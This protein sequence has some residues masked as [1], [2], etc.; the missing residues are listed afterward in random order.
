MVVRFLDRAAILEDKETSAEKQSPWRLATVT[1][2]EEMKLILNMI[3]IWIATLPF[4]VTVSQT[5]TF[6]TKPALSCL[7]CNVINNCYQQ[8]AKEICCSNHTKVEGNA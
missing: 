4:G 2:V 3:P 7:L 1:K 6:F 5:S 8:A